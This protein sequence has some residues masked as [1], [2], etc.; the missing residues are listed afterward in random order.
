VR[1]RPQ[2]TAEAAP[3]TQTRGIMLGPRRR[4]WVDV[5]PE[6]TGLTRVP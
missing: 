1:G 5:F 3:T 4:I 2:G 6:T